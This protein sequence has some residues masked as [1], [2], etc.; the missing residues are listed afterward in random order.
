MVASETNIMSRACPLSAS[1]AQISPANFL[2]ICD[3]C[4]GNA[5]EG[6][7]P[8]LLRACPQHVTIHPGRLRQKSM[9]R[10]AI[11]LSA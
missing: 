1:F 3:F 6:G 9:T 8:S 5:T 4:T 10:Y 7:S 2:Q 11:G